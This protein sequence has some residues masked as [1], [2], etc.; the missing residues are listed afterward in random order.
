MLVIAMTISA[1]AWC[2]AG[3]VARKDPLAH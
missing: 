3:S 2:M 1:A